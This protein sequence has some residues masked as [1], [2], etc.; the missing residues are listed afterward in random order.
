MNGGSL[1]WRFVTGRPD[2]ESRPEMLA[3]FSGELC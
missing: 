3:P 2:E 1:E